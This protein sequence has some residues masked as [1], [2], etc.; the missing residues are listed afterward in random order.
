[1]SCARSDLLS[2]DCMVYSTCQKKEPNGQ[3]ERVK[4]MVAPSIVPI[5]VAQQEWRRQRSQPWIY[6][7]YEQEPISAGVSS[8]SDDG[9]WSCKGDDVDDGT[10]KTLGVL[11]AIIGLLLG[12]GCLV[13]C[14]VA[15]QW[16]MVPVTLGLLFAPAI[17]LL[18]SIFFQKV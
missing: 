9:S 5:L 14:A 13:L 4:Q 3:R 11:T 2:V 7:Y 15:G 16:L 10:V 12:V 8:E 1:M 17:A 6:G 18:R